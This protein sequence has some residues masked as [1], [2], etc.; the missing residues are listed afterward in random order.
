LASFMASTSRLTGTRTVRLGHSR[1]LP[2]A[3]GAGTD[4]GG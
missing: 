4:R 2:G 3:L 1:L